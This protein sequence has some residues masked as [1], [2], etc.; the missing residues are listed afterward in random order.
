MPPSLRKF[1]GKQRFAPCRSITPPSKVPFDDNVFRGDS[2]Q[3]STFDGGIFLQEALDTTH[4]SELEKCT[5]TWVQQGF[6]TNHNGR[7]KDALNE[8]L[9]VANTSPLFAFLDPFNHAQLEFSDILPLLHRNAKTEIC[10]VF[11][12][13]LARRN[14]HALRPRNT[15]SEKIEKFRATLSDTMTRVFGDDQWKILVERGT[16][17][18]RDVLNYLGR[19]ILSQAR[20]G[21]SGEPGYFYTA[22]IY[23]SKGGSVKYHIVYWT[24]HIDGVELMN[25]TFHKESSDLNELTEK[26]LALASEQRLGGQQ[27]FF[28]LEL[29]DPKDV[30]VARQF[31]SL[32]GT[33]LDIGK[34]S[35]SK[36][37][38]RRELISTLIQERFGEY[39]KTLHRQA[40]QKLVD[41]PEIPK[42]VPLNGKLKKNNTWILNDDTQLRF[43][44]G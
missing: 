12:T 5:A 30:E 40:V 24:R 7:F 9:R 2:R 8:V 15:S 32:I 17:G 41:Q 31:N 20:F 1:S 13:Q 43:E 6:V 18:Q 4:F 34:K 16:L 27:S 42:I 25:D 23:D 28:G 3:R 39:S 37:W 29:E 21:F 10:A 36:V 33:I 35:P 19:R 14:L 11:F 26:Q 38:T 22:P 44:D